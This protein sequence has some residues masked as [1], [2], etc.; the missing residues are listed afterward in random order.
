MIGE[1]YRYVKRSEDYFDNCGND[2]FLY[3]VRSKKIARK[4]HDRVKHMAQMITGV[5]IPD[6]EDIANVMDMMQKEY[7]DIMEEKGSIAHENTVSKL[8]VALLGN[9][10]YQGKTTDGYGGKL[11]HDTIKAYETTRQFVKTDDPMRVPDYDMFLEHVI[12]RVFDQLLEQAVM[13]IRAQVEHICIANEPNS[14]KMQKR[15]RAHGIYNVECN[16][17]NQEE[18]GDP[19]YKHEVLVMPIRRS[20]AS[21]YL[22]K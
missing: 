12:K 2:P 3:V 22:K 5:T 6:Q 20:L 9:Q 18:S 8:R 11:S 15:H 14:I 13:R 10:A 16:R 21:I 7:Y 4:I 17:K 1:H 19:D